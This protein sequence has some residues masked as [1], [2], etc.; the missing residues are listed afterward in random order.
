MLTQRR[1]ESQ[2][3]LENLCLTPS[4]INAKHRKSHIIL[5]NMKENIPPLNTIKNNKNGL[6]SYSYSQKIMLQTKPKLNSKLVKSPN[7]NNNYRILSLPLNEGKESEIMNRPLPSYKDRYLSEL[8]G[9]SNQR[10]DAPTL[11]ITNNSPSNQQQNLAPVSPIFYKSQMKETNFVSPVSRQQLNDRSP[12]IL[13]TPQN[14]LKP[15]QNNYFEL[16]NQ[17]TTNGFQQQKFTIKNKSKY[18]NFLMPS[19][20]NEVT[21][22]VPSCPVLI[23]EAEIDYSPQM[24]TYTPN[25]KRITCQ[26]SRLIFKKYMDNSGEI[27]QNSPDLLTANLKKQ[28]LQIA[29]LNTSAEKQLQQIN[30]SVEKSQDFSHLKKYYGQKYEPKLQVKQQL[31]QQQSNRQPSLK[32]KKLQMILSQRNNIQ[33]INNQTTNAYFGDYEM[34]PW[35]QKSETFLTEEA[36]TSLIDILNQLSK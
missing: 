4:N 27:S 26:R 8:Q 1:L 23:D 20:N 16:I 13:K 18:N 12:F 25:N 5:N 22:K 34:K 10:D 6:I 30:N 14:S 31:Q 9:K 36:D 19:N 2:F 17:K 32:S 29:T 15:T 7:I 3:D 35:D 24:K 21:I 33:A 28:N 11:Q